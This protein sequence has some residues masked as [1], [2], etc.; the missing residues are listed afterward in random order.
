LGP[1]AAAGGAAGAA[2]LLLTPPDAFGRVAPWLVGGASLLLLAQPQVRRR[3]DG[4]SHE[5]SRLLFVAFVAATVY[6]G[7]FG[8]AGGVIL[9]AVL[10]PMLGE[11]LARTNAVKNAVSGMANA[12][13]ALGFMLFGPVV[14]VAAVPLGA[15]FLLGGAVGPALVRRVPETPLRALVAVAGIVVAVALAADAY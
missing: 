10:G 6:V 12:T 7:Y 8:A 11:S 14:W 2:L 4:A 13:A 1:A 5:S 9:L 15:G 3:V